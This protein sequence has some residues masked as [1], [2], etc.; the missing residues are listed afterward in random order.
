MILEVA[1]LDV[2]PGEGDAFEAAFA[3]AQSIIMSMHGYQG[4]ELQKC[5]EKENRYLLLVH[6]ETLED[7]TEGFRGSDEYQ[8][9]KRL[10]HHFYDP[11]PEV[12]HYEAVRRGTPGGA[13]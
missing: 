9:W 7:H 12:E 5:I 6:W 3:E 4:H 1:R 2:K 10:L 8:E 13:G 11:F